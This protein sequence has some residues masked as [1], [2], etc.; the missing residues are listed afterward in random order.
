[1][2]VQEQAMLQVAGAPL[3][4]SVVHESPSL[5]SAGQEAIGSQVSP[6]STTPL[7]QTGW[8]VS[9]LL[10]LQPAG[11]HPS[12]SPHSVIVSFAQ[13]RSHVDAAPVVLSIVQG[14][15]SSQSTAQEAIG[16]QVSPGSTMPLSHTGRHA[17]SSLALQPAGQQSSPSVQ[18]VIS[19]LE[20]TASHEE[21]LPVSRSLVQGSPSSQSVGQLAIGSQLSP[22]SGMPLLQ[23][24]VQSVSPADGHPIGQQPSPDSHAVTGA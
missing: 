17:S 2:D 6:D 18:V 21:A 20:Q 4:T 22:G 7:S 11:Q 8:Q 9:S 23:T 1:M 10:A 5:Q 15:L 14:S 19:V 12:P 16:S 13:A 24:P 3:A